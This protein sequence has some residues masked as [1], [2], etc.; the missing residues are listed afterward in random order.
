MLLVLFILAT[1]SLETLLRSL[2]CGRAYGVG[3]FYNL[4]FAIPIGL[5]CYFICLLFKKE[6]RNTVAVTLVGLLTV[7]FESQFVYFK[8]FRRFYTIYSVGNCGKALEFWQIMVMK[9]RNNFLGVVLLTIPF[10]LML[11]YRKKIKDTQLFEIKRRKLVTII[12]VCVMQLVAIL[13]LPLAGKDAYSPFDLYFNNTNSEISFEKIGLVASTSSEINR[14]IFNVDGKKAAAP[15]EIVIKDKQDNEIDIIDE[16]DATT[17]QDEAV[18]AMSENLSTQYDTS[19]YNVINID[20]NKLLEEAKAEGNEDLIELDEHFKDIVPTSKNDMTGKYKGYNLITITAEAFSPYAIRED[21]TPTLYRLTKEGLTF[22]NFYT[23]LWEV[24]TSDGEYTLFNSQIPKS[25]TWSMS[26]SSE[27]ELPFS[28]GNQLKKEGYKTMAFHNHDY[29]Y[30]NRDKSHPNLGYEYIAKGNGLEFEG[31]PESDVSLIDQTVDKY[32]NNQPFHTYYMTVS[33][34]M[35][36]SFKANDMSEVHEKEVEN[37]DMSEPARS[38]LAAQ[39]ELDHAVADL[40]EKLEKAG[41]LDNTLIS[42]VPDHYPYGLNNE[43]MEE[44]AGHPI[45]DNFDI[46][47]SVWIL[48]NPKMTP[49]VV[50]KPCSNLDVLPTLSNLMG[51]E[52]DSRFFVGSDVFSD[53]KPLVILYSH[54]FICDQGRYNAVAKEFISN[55]AQEVDKEEI[56]KLIDEVESKFYYS[57]KVLTTDYYRHVFK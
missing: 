5:A 27:N 30:Y 51:L 25:G 56:Q 3:L 7:L 52:F 48:Y 33:G 4:L 41:V 22:S 40:L 9:I 50:D 55:D 12:G 13:L 17:E 28:L 46:Y 15:D 10:V 32:V 35:D 16:A 14:M 11:I 26:A 2:V 8:I 47:R 18:A 43:Q 29:D 1:Y 44:I 54:H 38:Y 6:K 42:I 21:L 39:I 34:H 36:Y 37:L 20:F 19:K 53:S 49:Q 45:D 57:S 31:W 23:A 24:S